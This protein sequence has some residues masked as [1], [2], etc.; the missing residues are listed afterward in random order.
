MKKGGKVQSTICNKFWI[1]NKVLVFYF[2]GV[3]FLVLIRVVILPM[4]ETDVERRSPPITDSLLFACLFVV[5]FFFFEQ[6]YGVTCF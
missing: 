6:F 3:L 1:F 2:S 4:R 5:F